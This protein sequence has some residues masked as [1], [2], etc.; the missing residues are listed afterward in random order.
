MVAWSALSTTTGRSS[1]PP[2]AENRDD[3][4]IDESPLIPL[5]ERL[6]EAG[7]SFVTITGTHDMVCALEWRML[8]TA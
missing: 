3:V 2:D 7:E 6:L 4:F 5:I 8:P 1:R